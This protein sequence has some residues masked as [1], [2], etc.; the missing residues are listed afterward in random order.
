MRIL[1]SGATC[2]LPQG[3]AR[4][5]VLIEKGKIL[6]IDPPR[7]VQVDETIHAEDLFLL[8]GVVDAHVHFRDPGRLRQVCVH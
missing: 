4:V 7:G 3:P 5:D 2:V 1:I 8:P 6:G